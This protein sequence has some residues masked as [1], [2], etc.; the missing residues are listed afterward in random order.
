MTLDRSAEPFE[1]RT[2]GW[3]VAEAIGERMVQLAPDA[4]A[5]ALVSARIG[6]HLEAERMVRAVPDDHPELPPWA[7]R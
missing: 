7:P 6:L 1:E 5:Q 2:L 4:A 3:P